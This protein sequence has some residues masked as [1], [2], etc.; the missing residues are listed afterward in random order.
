MFRGPTAPSAGE[1]DLFLCGMRA[2]ITTAEHRRWPQQALVYLCT[3]VTG[4]EFFH[5]RTSCHRLL[6]LLL[7]AVLVM[8]AWPAAPVAAARACAGCCTHASMNTA[9]DEPAPCCRLTPDVPQLPA[10]AVAAPDAIVGPGAVTG[11]TPLDRR[12]ARRAS[13]PRLSDRQL[14]LLRLSVI[15][16]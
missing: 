8:A 9:G 5:M 4:G 6:A 16:A 3:Q 12:P 1:F 7:T 14:R 10:V 11:M 13:P 2:A 15:R